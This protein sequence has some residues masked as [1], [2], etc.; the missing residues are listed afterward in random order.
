MLAVSGGAAWPEPGPG[1]GAAGGGLTRGPLSPQAFPDNAARREVES[2]PAVCPSEGC[3]WKGTLKEYEVGAAWR[4]L[5]LPQGSVG[6]HG[7]EAAAAGVAGRVAG[8]G[9]LAIC[10]YFLGWP[11]GRELAVCGRFLGWPGDEE[12]R[13]ARGPAWPKRHTGEESAFSLLGL[14]CPLTECVL[15]GGCRSGLL[16]GP[17]VTGRRLDEV[18]ATRAVAGCVSCGPLWQVGAPVCQPPSGS[19]ACR[20][21]VSSG[22]GPGLLRGPACHWRLSSAGR[23]HEPCPQHFP[24]AGCCPRKTGSPRC[25]GSYPGL[26]LVLRTGEPAPGCKG[27]GLG[28]SR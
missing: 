18:P 17:G 4:R 28:P 2:L 13:C 15:A 20:P 11:G 25:G 9:E 21:A 14:C 3:S 24:V 26:G 16:V 23:P 8:G 1:P 12:Q 19:R 10:G 5:C 7:G 6:F 27:R 22:A